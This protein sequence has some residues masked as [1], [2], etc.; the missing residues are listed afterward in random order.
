MKA[1]LCEAKPKQPHRKSP[2]GAKPLLNVRARLRNG[3]L[4]R[5]GFMVFNPNIAKSEAGQSPNFLCSAIGNLSEILRF[6][7]GL[8]VLKVYE[9]LRVAL[10]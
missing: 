9:A 3:V 10:V 1:F 5:F 7:D 6:R 8:F 4:L 2:H